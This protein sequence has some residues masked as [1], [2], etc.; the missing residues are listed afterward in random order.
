MSSDPAR[1]KAGLLL[2]SIASVR[3]RGRLHR[4]WG[5]RFRTNQNI[6]IIARAGR[7][8]QCVVLIVVM[9]GGLVPDL[10]SRAGRFEF[11]RSNKLIAFHGDRNFELRAFFRR[12]RLQAAQHLAQTANSYRRIRARQRNHIFN[13]ATDLNVRGRKK[14]D[15]TRTDVPRFLRTVDPLIAQLDNLER[16]F[17]FVPLSTSLF[18]DLYFINI[19][20]V[21]QL[22]MVPS[23]NF[24]NRNNSVGVAPFFAAHLVVYA[25]LDQRSPAI[26]PEADQFFLCFGNS[27]SLHG[28]CIHPRAK[29]LLQV[30]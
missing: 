12:G 13:A 9:K 2:R 28:S 27:R 23:L 25:Q 14:A 29:Y 11:V 6:Y 8:V 3:S 1:F 17:E 5:A 7:S 21:N 24:V 19:P 15:T 22:V 20:V 26:G 18:Q 10:G 16:K 30:D 4:H